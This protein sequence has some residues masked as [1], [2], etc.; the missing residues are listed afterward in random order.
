MIIMNKKI[1]TNLN[2][3]KLISIV[4][5]LYFLI[6]AFRIMLGHSYSLLLDVYLSPF[7]MIAIGIIIGVYYFR[8][9]IIPRLKK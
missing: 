8:K 4:V 9:I 7:P 5:I 1:F 2:Q 6:I 3:I